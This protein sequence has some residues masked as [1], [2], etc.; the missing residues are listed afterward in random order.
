MG[1]LSLVQAVW[2]VGWLVGFFLGGRGGFSLLVG[3]LL[4]YV[5]LLFDITDKVRIKPGT[6]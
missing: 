2:G 3:T 1:L 4:V 5:L 6:I